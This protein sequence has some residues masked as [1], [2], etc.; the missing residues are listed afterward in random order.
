MNTGS[1]VTFRVATHADT[2]ALVALVESAYRGDV[3]KQG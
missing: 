1:H 2:P 3:S